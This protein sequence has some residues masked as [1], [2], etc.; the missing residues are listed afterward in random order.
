GS[1]GLPLVVADSR[2]R[3]EPSVSDAVGRRAAGRRRGR[4]APGEAGAAMM[5]T[6]RH[7]PR[8]AFLRGCGAALALPLLDAMG[9]ALTALAKTAAPPV[10]RLGIV[11][12]PNGMNVW[13]W[14]PTAT[15]R[16]STALE[17]TPILE[18]LAPF[19]DRLLLVSGLSNPQADGVAGEGGGD[20]S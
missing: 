10:R 18:P 5:I 6:R 4:R 7:L 8:R 2:H 1:S 13:K 9:P 14:R 20:H 17:L 15:A 19:R 11:Y 16:G 3:H 12:A